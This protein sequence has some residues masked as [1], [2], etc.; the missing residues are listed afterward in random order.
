MAKIIIDSGPLYAL[1]DF[2]EQFPL[3]S[4]NVADPVPTL[5]HV[6]GS[7]NRNVLSHFQIPAGD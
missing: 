5:G 6:R 4:G 2:R 3:V 7:A 1:I